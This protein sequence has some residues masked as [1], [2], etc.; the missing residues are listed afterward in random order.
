ML[1]ALIDADG[2]VKEAKVL[3]GHP[4][5]VDAALEAVQQWRYSSA[6][7]NGEPWPVELDVTLVFQLR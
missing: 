6:L 4:L 5:L 2:G 3:E 1:Q 7:M